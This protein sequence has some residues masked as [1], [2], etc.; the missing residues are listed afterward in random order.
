V[1]VGPRWFPSQLALLEFE[2]SRKT[3]N[4]H[5]LNSHRSRIVAAHLPLAGKT[6]TREGFRERSF[7]RAGLVSRRGNLMQVFHERPHRAIHAL[8]VRILR[9]NDVVFVRRM[10]PTSVAEPKM[11]GGKT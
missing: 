5:R 2:S 11:P 7:A 6:K 10:G 9:L 4:E 1:L 3:V 8:H